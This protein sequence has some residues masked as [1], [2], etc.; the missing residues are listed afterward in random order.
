MDDPSS[1]SGPRPKEFAPVSKV[2]RA[3]IRKWW[4]PKRRRTKISPV[5]RRKPWRGALW[6][7]VALRGRPSVRRGRSAFRAAANR[8]LAQFPASRFGV[9]DALAPIAPVWVLCSRPAI[10][11]GER[12]AG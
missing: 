7:S 2:D 10:M 1:R 11:F 6:D 12:Y 9:V 8:M 5:G 4:P 3:E